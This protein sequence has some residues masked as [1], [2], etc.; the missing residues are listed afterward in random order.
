M[1]SVEHNL[2]GH[3]AGGSRLQ[4]VIVMIFANHFICNSKVCEPEVPLAVKHNVLRLKI[5]MNYIFLVTSIQGQ[6][7]ASYIELGALRLKRFL[8]QQMES[9]VTP[10]EQV[11][12]QVHVSWVM[13]S[14][15]NIY[16][17]F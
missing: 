4:L 11:D 5:P 15:L 8:F 6:S 3:V 1:V 17:K 10:I 12:D 14:I 13:E 7:D 16:N 9:E 2:R